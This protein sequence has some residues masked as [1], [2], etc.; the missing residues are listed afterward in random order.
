MLPPVVRQD[1]VLITVLGDGG[2]NRVGE[3]RQRVMVIFDGA[4][5]PEVDLDFLK[6]AR[7]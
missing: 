7:L 6:P 4:L 3:F 2:E 1:Q 5:L